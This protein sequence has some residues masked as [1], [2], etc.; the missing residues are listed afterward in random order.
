MSNHRAF[1]CPC[2]D[3]ACRSWGVDPVASHQGE[4]FTERTA[5]AT[6]R[7]LNAL[8][9]YDAHPAGKIAQI[10]VYIGDLP[11]D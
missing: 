1:K 2:G 11:L 8:E 7:F 10:I 9:T 3:K 4:H 6:A 5:K